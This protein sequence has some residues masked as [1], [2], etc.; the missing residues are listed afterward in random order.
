[1]VITRDGEYYKLKHERRQYY[2]WLFG[3][4][5]RRAL[6]VLVARLGPMRDRRELMEIVTRI[7]EAIRKEKDDGKTD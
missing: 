2:R 1:M 6:T 7:E 5:G 3:R 4:R